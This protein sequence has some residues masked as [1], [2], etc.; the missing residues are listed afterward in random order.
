VGSG[1]ETRGGAR[2]R[3]P[4]S[5][6]GRIPS[7]GSGMWRVAFKVQGAHGGVGNFQGIRRFPCAVRA[8]LRTLQSKRLVDVFP[9]L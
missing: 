8:A 5:I 2:F 9:S 4:I 6:F 3:P 1:V 7:A